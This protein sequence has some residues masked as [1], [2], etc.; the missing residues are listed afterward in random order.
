VSRDG[1]SATGNPIVPAKGIIDDIGAEII[2]R[3]R[4]GDDMG[5]P[6]R[7]SET[8]RVTGGPREFETD[9]DTPMTPSDLFRLSKKPRPVVR[10]QLTC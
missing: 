10:L 7:A 6:R 8:S 5:K 9:T 3:A 4:C 1:I 2:F